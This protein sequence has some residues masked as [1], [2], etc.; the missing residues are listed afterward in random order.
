MTNHFRYHQQVNALYA[1]VEAPFGPW[2]LQ[3]GLRGE[4]THVA[5]LQITGDIPGGRNDAAVYPSLHL[6]RAFGDDTKVSVSLARRVTRPDPEALN[7]FTDFQDTHNLRAG[8]ANLL[9]QDTWIYE[10]G[11]TQAVRSLTL[12]AQAYYRFDRNSVTDV[13]Q[14]VSADVVLDTKENLPK[15]RSE[16]LEFNANGKLGPMISFN[17]SGELFHAQIDAG[18]LGLPGLRSTTGANLKGGL[19]FRPT[20]ADTAQVSVSRQDRRLTPHGSIDPINQVNLGYR[21]QLRPD[22]SFVVTVSDALD[23]QR[24]RRVVDSPVL[25]DVYVRHQ[26]GRIA[27]AGFVY[28]FGGGSKKAQGFDY[29]P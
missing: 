13:I 21:R 8:N 14:P 5:T 16:G 27:Y 6:D 28:T 29:E 23:G 18:A 24:L 19:D 11:V 17:L 20:P 12:G 1:Q 25:Q 9:P 15:S 2:R 26:L 4:V 22:L 7:P 3:A 10:A